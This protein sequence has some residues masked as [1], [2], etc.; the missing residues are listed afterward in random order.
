MLPV[1]EIKG[2]GTMPRVAT[3][4]KVTYNDKLV[5]VKREI[6]QRRKVYSRLV[7]EGKMPA[8]LANFR[9]EVMLS[10]EKDYQ[11]AVSLGQFQMFEKVEA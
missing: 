11:G 1:V 5:E 2:A 9:I 6:E 10:I 8:H 4:Y 3:E 7:K